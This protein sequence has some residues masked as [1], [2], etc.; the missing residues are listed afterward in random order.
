[1]TLEVIMDVKR[2]SNNSWALGR[3]RDVIFFSCEYVLRSGNAVQTC[4]YATI[5]GL[6]VHTY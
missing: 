5:C 2:G 1:M 4:I 3:W 6:V